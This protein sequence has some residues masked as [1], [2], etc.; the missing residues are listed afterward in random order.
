[1]GIRCIGVAHFL[2]DL[3]CPDTLFALDS[4]SRHHL[5]PRREWMAQWRRDNRVPVPGPV[6][7]CPRW[8]V[9]RTSVWFVCPL[10]TIG[11]LRSVGVAWTRSNPHYYVNYTG[12]CR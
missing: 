2:L 6:A 7:V 4:S 3:G 5:G 1:M 11:G 8:V 9:N 12:R 10:E